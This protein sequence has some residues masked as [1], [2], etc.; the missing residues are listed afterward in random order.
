MCWGN[1]KKQILR[2]ARGVVLEIG[3]GTGE[4]VRHYPTRQNQIERIYGVE[5]NLKK[6][7]ILRYQAQKLGMKDKYEVVASGIEN[8][9]V[10]EKHGIENQSVDTVVCVLSLL[11]ELICRFTVCVV[12]PTLREPLREFM[13]CLNQADNSFFLN[14]LG[15]IIG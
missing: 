12:S 14:T 1:V 8:V 5:P 2:D 4:T 13:A 11:I 10:L 15:Q 9:D 7:A 3:A 6:C